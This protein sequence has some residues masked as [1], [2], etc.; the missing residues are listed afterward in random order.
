MRTVAFRRLVVANVLL[1]LPAVA[2]ADDVARYI[3][4]GLSAEGAVE[5]LKHQ[6]VPLRVESRRE[7]DVTRFVAGTPAGA[8]RIAIQLHGASGEVLF[9]DAVE[10][11]RFLHDHGRPGE[12]AIGTRLVELQEKAF[13]VRLPVLARTRLR[14]GVVKGTPSDV[15]ARLPLRA[16]ETE[17]DVDA[18]AANGALPLSRFAPETTRRVLAGGSAAASGADNR[19][20]LLIMGDGYT[21]SEQAK[22]NAD[23]DG[24]FRTFFDIPPYSIYRNFV[25]T[26][27]LYTASGQSG[28][29]HPPY[30]ASC[31]GVGVPTCCADT[32]MQNDPKRGTFVTTAFDAGFCLANT[33][34]LLYVNAGKV[35]AAAAASP[36]WDKILVVV[37]DD[38]YGGAG[39]NVGS[40]STNA[41][42]VG[43][44]QHEFG[45]SFTGLAD[46]YTT[47]YPGYPACSDLRGGA[48][49]ANVTDVTDRAAI[50]WRSWILPSTPIPTTSGSA[51][52]LFQGARY[53]AAGMYRPKQSCLMNSLGQPFC[54]VCAQEFVLQLYQGGWGVPASGID[55]VEP[56]S[57]SPAPGDV[58]VALPGS[59]TFSVDL[60]SP[61]GGPAVTATWL[62][63]GAPAGT[64]RSFVFTPS[65]A[66]RTTVTLLYGDPTPLVKPDAAGTLLA[67]T[68]TWTVNASSAAADSAWVIPSTARATGAGGAF[69]TT[70][71][72][73]ANRGAVDA[74]FTVKFL[75]HDQDGTSGSEQTFSLA[76]GKLVTYDD[77]LGSLFGVTSGFGAVR[78][79]SGAPSLQVVA[80]T[81]T[82]GAGGTFG[83]SVP[84]AT[85][86]D[87]IGAEPRSILPVRDDAGSRTNLIVV[88]TSAIAA[89]LS[90]SLVGKDGVVLWTQSLTFRPLEMR[91]LSRVALFG[92]VTSVVDGM[93]V[94]STP[95]P[96]AAFA[97]Y[98]SVID[99]ATN[100]PRTLLPR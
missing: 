9:R 30:Q 16:V 96:G 91:Q 48:C 65:R 51:V 81:S 85:A 61:V 28:A 60:L 20:D 83:Q 66:G 69:Y 99:N 94:L 41:Q 18:L 67:R 26:T 58:T 90:V 79:T 53:Q 19:L 56:G 12:P 95:T 13:V 37:N 72:T 77:V 32:T 14:L 73:V 8:D 45:H 84:S 34:R 70:D 24:V 71:L 36:G 4:F 11:P 86:S 88:N 31:S 1:S 39:G 29:D 17:L 44:A 42:A 35:L 22:F 3:V 2:V 38:T 63:D 33:H 7:E 43:I 15:A 89:G 80:Q 100:D 49:E 50:K 98:A 74:A 68:R 78:V 87:L 23:A 52:G 6:L 92:R 76:A 59:V 75:G 40:F 62:V 47:A 55:N 93:L 25:R 21:A 97:A 5:P 46:E 27:S 10:V 54:E 57:E 82:P 64:G